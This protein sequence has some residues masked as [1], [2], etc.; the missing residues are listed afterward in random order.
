[1]GVVCS[2]I[3]FSALSIGLWARFNELG[4]WCLAVDE[5]YIAKAVEQIQKNGF[6]V[7]PDGGI[8]ARAL[9]FQYIET[10]SASIFGLNEYA[11]RLPPILFNLASIPPL[12]LLAKKRI[13]VSGGLLLVAFFG[14]SVWEIE[15]ARFARMYSMF[16]CAFLW[17][18]YC[19]HE[20]FILERNRAIFWSYAIAAMSIFI[21]AASIFMALLLFLP[22]F[23]RKTSIVKQRQFGMWAG[24]ILLL[25]VANQKWSLFAM[26]ASQINP[27]PKGFIPPQSNSGV[28]LSP[29][30]SLWQS[31]FL[32]GGLWELGYCIFALI[33][34]GIAYKVLVFHHWEWRQKAIGLLLLVCSLLQVYGIV[35]FLLLVGYLTQMIT[36]KQIINDS[37][38]KRMGL[39]VMALFGFW[40]AFGVLTTSW[41]G[42]VPIQEFS[43]HK[44]FAILLHYPRFG[45]KFVFPW[46]DVMPYFFMVACFFGLIVLWSTRKSEKFLQHSFLLLVLVSCL[47]V[48][49][50][51]N[52]GSQTRYSFF[53]YPIILLLWFEGAL[54][55]KLWIVSVCPNAR[56]VGVHEL[57]SVF[58]PFGLLLVSED[59]SFYRLMNISKAEVNFRM[60]SRR[61]VAN[62]YYQRHDFKAP[63]EYINERWKPSDII[64][65][66]KAFPAAFYLIPDSYVYYDQTSPKFINYATRSGTKE[67]WGF[68]LV[69]NKETVQVAVQS[70]PGA[71]WILSDIDPNNKPIDLTAWV[72]DAFKSSSV[73]MEII[74]PGIDKRIQVVKFVP[75]Y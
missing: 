38:T 33:G 59:F 61:N 14:V 47:V 64:I 46:F 30:F 67:R 12:Y 75:Q 48:L 54:A 8:Y 72:K 37:L 55:L 53:L 19:Y 22:L 74:F 26:E 31:I 17:F 5:F 34:L 43:L 3:C 23:F 69:H 10:A 39:F 1:M 44:L 40:L 4:A 71:V 18:L 62:H 60:N 11:L 51:I 45:E 24:L 6:P 36:L 73:N 58:I 28:L 27:Y 7:Y 16:Q 35:F 25:N 21:H 41:H 29:D 20:G 68:P 70:M 66:N 2:L 32:Q 63:A 50:L 42:L 57:A 52:A 9:L 15:F 13:G 56:M 49:G 65:I